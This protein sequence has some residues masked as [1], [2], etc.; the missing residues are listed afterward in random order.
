VRETQPGLRLCVAHHLAYGTPL[1]SPI[2]PP[3]PYPPLPLHHLPRHHLLVMIW[4]AVDVKTE[5][6]YIHVMLAANGIPYDVP[7]HL[8]DSAAFAGV[9]GQAFLVSCPPDV[10]GTASAYVVR[11][12]K[13]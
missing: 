4:A 1:V 2:S 13:P 9:A 10:G 12:V 5:S 3:P 6:Q 7:R 8:P 11:R